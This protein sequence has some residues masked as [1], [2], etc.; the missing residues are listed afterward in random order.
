MCDAAG[1]WQSRIMH[2]SHTALV[3]ICRLLASSVRDSDVVKYAVTATPISMQEEQGFDKC[4]R[5]MS[6]RIG[7]VSDGSHVTVWPCGRT[8]LLCVS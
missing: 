7:D 1:F 6:C 5:A 3:Q 4:G 8:S 2:A